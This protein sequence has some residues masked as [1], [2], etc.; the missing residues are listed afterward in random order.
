MAAKA[1]ASDDDGAGAGDT[2]GGGGGGEDDGDH[3]SSSAIDAAIVV[4]LC[5]KYAFGSMEAPLT[6]AQH[7]L[8]LTYVT[9]L[10]HAAGHGKALTI[11]SSFNLRGQLLPA[12]AVIPMLLKTKKIGEL[13]SYAESVEQK[14]DVIT[15]AITQG[16]N[17]FADKL[18]SKWKLR[19]MFPGLHEKA[20]EES[21]SKL[22]AQGKVHQALGLCGVKV[23]EKVFLVAELV[24]I[25]RYTLAREIRTEGN[26]QEELAPIPD[27][28]DKTFADDFLKLEIEGGVD[29]H[30]HWVATTAELNKM[31]RMLQ[32]DAAARLLQAQAAAAA[33]AGTSNSDGDSESSQAPLD[34]SLLA[35]VGL[36]VEWKP[37]WTRCVCEVPPA[38]R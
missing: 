11:E 34:A 25:G 12:G 17:R 6:A 29:E 23:V 4:K 36:D 28:E 22:V 30:V 27:G 21:L 32:A 16:E 38:S 35:V 24:R 10:W 20:R 18:S 1:E 3:G 8:L 19:W 26:V 7:A 15:L 5:K 33:V 2:G 14:S 31:H 37:V 9:G 13:E